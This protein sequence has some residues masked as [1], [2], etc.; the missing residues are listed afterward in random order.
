MRTQIS[1]PNLKKQCTIKHIAIFGGADVDPMHPLYQET[2]K[3]ARYL[4]YH[5][6]VIINGG[7]PGVMNAATEGAESVGGQT[8]AVTFFPK[9]MPNFE[10]RFGRIKL[11]KKSRQPTTSSECLRSCIM[12]M[13]M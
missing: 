11:I 13:P 3:V 7:G 2:F 5:G 1:I 12:L 10:G 6:K 9:D 4:A 8:L